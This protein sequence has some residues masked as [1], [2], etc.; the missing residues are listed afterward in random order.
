MEEKSIRVINYLSLE[1]SLMKQRYRVSGGS[2][3]LCCR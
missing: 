3:M 1:V 2:E